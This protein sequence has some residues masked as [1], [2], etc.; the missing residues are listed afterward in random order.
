[1]AYKIQSTGRWAAQARDANGKRIQL[2]TY[3]TKREATKAEDAYKRRRPVGDTT[4]SEWRDHWLTHGQWEES[5]RKHHEERT[6][7]F[8]EEHGKKRL[9]AVNRTIARDFVKEHPSCHQSLSAMFGAAMYEDDEH[10]DPLLPFNPFSKL[11]KQKAKKRDLQSEWL[12]AEEVEQIEETA[13]RTVGGWAASFVRFAAEEGI[14]PGELYMV[15]ETDLN[16][17]AG[18]LLVRWAADS[19]TRVI[20]RP[21][22]GRAREIVLSRRALAAARAL[23]DRDD[24]TRDEREIV[25]KK[26]RADATA[27]ELAPTR[28]IF[29]NPRGNQFWNSTWSYYWHQIRAAAGRPDMDFYELRHYCATRLLEAG[30]SERDVAEQL[31]HTDGGELVR[32]VYGHPSKRRALDRVRRVLDDHDEED[33]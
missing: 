9:G 26:L 22:N 20:K 8:N 13:F 19:K 23:I 27:A 31:G 10:G 3:A 32:K 12:T 7:R 25:N 16:P 30:L 2:G 21:K 11:V 1:M 6:K 4:V 28:L 24:V 5:T 17:D 15:G 14:R 33:A 18:T 29:T